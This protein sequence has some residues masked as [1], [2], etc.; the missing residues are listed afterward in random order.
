MTTEPWAYFNGRFI[1]SSQARLS[2][3]DTGFVWGA[4]A[5]DRIRTFKQKLFR[6]DD[7]LRR[8][9]KSCDSAFIP[10]LRTNE[11][12]AQAAEELVR[13]NARLL[14]TPGAEFSLV[15]VATPGVAGEPTL[16]MQARPIDFSRYAHLYSEGAILETVGPPFARQGIDPHIKHRSRLAWWIAQ[17]QIRASANPRAAGAEPL[18]TT[19]L[20]E[21]FIR[22]TPIANIIV[23]IQG[24]LFSPPRNEILEGIS[25]RVIEELCEQLGIPFAERELTLAEVQS[26]SNECLL[27]NTTYCLAPVARIGNV[28]KRIAGPLFQRLIQAW[29]EM[30]GVDIRRQ[31]SA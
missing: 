2:I 21:Q 28:E 10:Q 24:S 18:F 5:T 1:P 6:L 17:E 29:S 11:E 4:T 8:F 25:L 23:E 30:V 20:P 14:P 19:A 31:F 3:D 7:H 15:L 27:S 26:V 9:G 13:A 22:E 12:L 16:G